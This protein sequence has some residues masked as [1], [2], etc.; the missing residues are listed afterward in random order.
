MK[1]TLVCNDED[2]KFSHV[3]SFEEEH[4]MR[5]LENIELF[6]RGCGY[7]F[8]SLDINFKED[9]CCGNCNCSVDKIEIDPDAHEF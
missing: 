8:D 2:N 4:I 7:Y 6:L 1:F 5:V 3:S 9:S